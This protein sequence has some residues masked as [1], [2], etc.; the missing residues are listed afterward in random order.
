MW[1]LP[2]R[3]R[4]RRDGPV[5]PSGVEEQPYPDGSELTIEIVA[6]EANVTG[7]VRHQSRGPAATASTS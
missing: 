2:Q 1:S 4:R 7:R 5:T 3:P 6:G